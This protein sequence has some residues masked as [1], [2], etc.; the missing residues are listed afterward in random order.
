MNGADHDD[1]DETT[2]GEDVLVARRI[3][4]GARNW[5]R[6]DELRTASCTALLDLGWKSIMVRDKFC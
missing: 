1:D 3:I 5:E 2:V 4:I 6:N